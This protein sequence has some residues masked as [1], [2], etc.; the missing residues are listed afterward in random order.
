LRFRVPFPALLQETSTSQC[1]FLLTS[2][3]NPEPSHPV[4]SMVMKNLERSSAPSF[5]LAREFLSLRPFFLPASTGTLKRRP[6]LPRFASQAKSE[7]LPA[8]FRVHINSCPVILSHPTPQ[9]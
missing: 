1:S 2:A 5:P 6:L 3:R 7:F 9:D 4:I 8:V